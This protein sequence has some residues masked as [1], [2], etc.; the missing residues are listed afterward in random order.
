MIYR[1]SSAYDGE[2]SDVSDGSIDPAPVPE[3]DQKHSTEVTLRNRLVA[4]ER[5]SFDQVV[6]SDADKT[7]NEMEQIMELDATDAAGSS[8]KKG[9][10][11]KLAEQPTSSK[12]LRLNSHNEQTKFQTELEQPLEL[13]NSETSFINKLLLPVSSV[14]KELNKSSAS[15]IFKNTQE[16][17][18]GNTTKLTCRENIKTA[19]SLMSMNQDETSVNLN[20]ELLL[21]KSPVQIETAAVSTSPM[22]TSTPI[23][24]NITLKNYSIKPASLATSQAPVKAANKVTQCDAMQEEAT[25]PLY[26]IDLSLSPTPKKAN[27][28][29][30]SFSDSPPVEIPP[31]T[32]SDPPRSVH[33]KINKPSSQ[34]KD[35]TEVDRHNK[36]ESTDTT[37]V[38]LPVLGIEKWDSESSVFSS[39]TLNTADYANELL[40]DI[41]EEIEADNISLSNCLK[42]M[43]EAEMIS[44]DMALLVNPNYLHKSFEQSNR[45]T[46]LD[47]QDDAQ[48]CFGRLVDVLTNLDWKTLRK[49]HKLILRKLCRLSS[50]ENYDSLQ[51]AAK[52]ND[53]SL[54]GEDAID[55]KLHKQQNHDKKRNISL[56]D[57]VTS[58]IVKASGHPTASDEPKTSA[59][60][61]LSA[62]NS[63]D[64]K[65][66]LSKL[67]DEKI[68][69]ARQVWGILGA[70]ENFEQTTLL[71]KCL[72]NLRGPQLQNFHR[73]F[74]LEQLKTVMGKDKFDEAKEQLGASKQTS[75]NNFSAVGASELHGGAVCCD[76]IM[77]EKVSTSKNF[78]KYEKNVQLASLLT[79]SSTTSDF[80]SN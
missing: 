29:R 25:I 48:D 43:V 78:E 47:F 60:D 42:E 6:N 45:G 66:L 73:I 12:L 54:W 59:R 18:V 79:S 5:C 15:I 65:Q 64:T 46:Q 75:F 44:H 52:L 22:L 31:E 20:S 9:R 21:K 4:K 17:L 55:S 26:N 39:N 35:L 62:S 34:I 72:V 61:P 3:E 28:H 1:S 74:N 41:L 8:L 7:I 16:K 67:T 69:A 27:F 32:F 38:A 37:S 77:V 30:V 19:K 71:R 40:V 49:C 68:L 23:N 50:K 63:C 80:K 58:E 14:N 70:E 56:S 24:L 13:A 33:E 36:T 10:K 2:V 51:L 57:H 53:S 76:S 11:Q